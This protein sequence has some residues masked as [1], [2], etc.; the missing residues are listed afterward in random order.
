MLTDR[1]IPR[2]AEKHASQTGHSL[3]SAAGSSRL[4]ELGNGSQPVRANVGGE[5]ARLVGA[6][7]LAGRLTSS[8]IT[9]GASLGNPLRETVTLDEFHHQGA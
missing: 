8:A 5:G 7:W 4:P 2:C 6:P 9:L 1:Q 3:M